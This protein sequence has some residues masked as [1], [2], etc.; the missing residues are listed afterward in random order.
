V[1]LPGEI[2]RPHAMACDE[3]HAAELATQGLNE[4]DSFIGNALKDGSHFPL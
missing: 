4:D 1:P 3:I 2:L